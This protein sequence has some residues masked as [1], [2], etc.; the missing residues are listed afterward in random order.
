MIYLITTTILMAT[1]IGLQIWW[2]RRTIQ[3][4]L[5]VR[6]NIDSLNELTSEYLAH[7]KHVH[8]LE[9]YYGDETLEELIS[10]GEELS[11][12]VESFLEIFADYSDL[13]KVNLIIEGED[14]LDEFEESL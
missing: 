8:S 1:I 12:S 4:M 3:K 10:H 9:R 13:E 6:D 2:A 11:R 14:T 7:I 5:L